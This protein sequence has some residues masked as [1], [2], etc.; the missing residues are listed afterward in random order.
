MIHRLGMWDLPKGKIEAGETPKKAA[1][2]EVK[3][4]CGIGKLKITK[5]LPSTYHTYEMKG[6][7][8][9]K[10]TF[11]YEMMC[12]D[13]SPLIPQVEEHIDEAKWMT[14][15]A[16]KKM[17]ETNTYRSILEVLNNKE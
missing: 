6:K 7:K 2:R 4:E 17:N 1:I 16:L 11:W 13:D 8:Y 14:K 3:E 9:L 5:E 12:H 15:S 10:R